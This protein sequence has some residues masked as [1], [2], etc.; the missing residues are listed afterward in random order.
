MPIGVIGRRSASRGM[1]GL[2]SA[3]PT[4]SR[5]NSVLVVVATGYAS[6][7]EAAQS[8]RRPE[9]SGDGRADLDDLV[10]RDVRPLAPRR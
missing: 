2:R 1:P 4:S 5:V 8:R 6:A 3:S 9:S 7:C 10:G